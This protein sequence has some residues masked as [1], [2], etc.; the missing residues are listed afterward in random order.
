MSQ[1]YEMKQLGTSACTSSCDLSKVEGG[2][3]RAAMDSVY[4]G[5]S[6]LLG[7]HYFSISTAR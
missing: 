3:W 7:R 5:D 6:M 1:T 2:A 4:Q